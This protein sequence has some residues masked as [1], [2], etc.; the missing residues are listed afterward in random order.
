MIRCDGKLGIE[1]K[2]NTAKVLLVTNPNQHIL[3]TGGSNYHTNHSD[4]PVA[5]HNFRNNFY[6]TLNSPNLSIGK[7]DIF[8]RTS[9]EHMNITGISQE[10][11]QCL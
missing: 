1:G 11:Y 3:V 10:L 8:P 5:L 7:I 4:I 6:T 2:L 9:L